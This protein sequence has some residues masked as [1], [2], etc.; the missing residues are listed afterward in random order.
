MNTKSIKNKIKKNGYHII[1][2]FIE[3]NEI[4]IFLRHLYKY[5]KRKKI[6]KKFSY[7]NNSIVLHTGKSK[8]QQTPHNYISFKM[9]DLKKTTRTIYK[10]KKIYSKV[11][12]IQK[13]LIKYDLIKKLGYKI[14][15]EIIYYE[16]NKGFLGNH[17]HLLNPQYYGYV[18][19]LT[20]EIDKRSGHYN[21]KKKIS[22][23]CGDLLIF[24]INNVHCVKKSKKQIF[25]T[26]NFN[27]RL[28]LVTPIINTEV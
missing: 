20:D 4:E 24:K 5:F 25:K 9:Y 27:G 6:L 28:V 21:L 22:L 14:Y 13:K 3:K 18:L 19:G 11:L 8:Y 10:F 7:K 15:P 1:N 2:N 16:N 17:V 12:S 23:N 26:D